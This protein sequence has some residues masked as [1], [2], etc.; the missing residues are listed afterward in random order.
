MCSR[1]VRFALCVST[2]WF[3]I[4]A[5]A[6]I[7]S[8]CTSA[9]GG[10]MLVSVSISMFLMMDHNTCEYTKFLKLIK[11]LRLNWI[12]CYWRHIV[13]DQL[14]ELNST[15]NDVTGGCLQKN[16]PGF[17][18]KPDRSKQIEI[19]HAVKYGPY[20]LTLPSSGY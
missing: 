6:S 12:C 2:A 13:N 8:I 1:T 7:L 16:S 5:G 14:Q 4:N 18:T 19:C 20:F 11:R 10:F 17:M 3:G 9:G 15:L